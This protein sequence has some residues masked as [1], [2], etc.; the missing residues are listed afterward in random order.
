MARLCAGP[1]HVDSERPKQGYLTPPQEFLDIVDRPPE[2]SLSFSPDRRKILQMLRPPPMPPISELARPELK[3]AGA[4]VDPDLNAQSRMGHYRGLAL[5]DFT[6]DLVVPAPAEL[7]TLVRCR[8][9]ACQH[10]PGFLGTMH[11][12]GC[13]SCTA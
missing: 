3:L 11:A 2:P 8:A 1:K 12:P 6:P 9:R 4:R 5:V 10:V 7:Q 13:K